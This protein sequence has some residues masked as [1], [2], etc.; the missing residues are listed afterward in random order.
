MTINAF[1]DFV[2]NQIL[3][4]KPIKNKL[5][6]AREF[7]GVSLLDSLHIRSLNSKWEHLYVLNIFG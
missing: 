2:T 7:S 1:S 3:V 6:N 4:L 5:W